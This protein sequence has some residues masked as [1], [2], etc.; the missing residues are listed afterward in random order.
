MSRKAGD[1]LSGENQQS[2][3]V[4]TSDG[5]EIDISP[6]KVIRL[7][8]WTI[9]LAFGIFGGWALTAPLQSAAHAPG[10]VG[11]RGDKKTVQ[12]YEGG[13]VE[14][15]LVA[16]GDS[17]QA[18]QVL[19]ELD[20]TQSRAQLE[21]TN[22]Q[23]LSAKAE[24]AR[25]MAEQQGLIRIAYVGEIFDS[26]D[27][28]AQ[29]AMIQQ[30]KVF[31]ARQKSRFGE[32]EVLEQKIEQ[33]KSRINGKKSLV[34]GK[35]QLV[36]SYLEEI[37]DYKALVEQGYSDKLRLRE[38]ERQ[39]ATLQSEIADSEASIAENMIEIGEARLE[40]IQ[41]ERRFQS[42]VA[43]EL[44]ETQDR[45]FEMMERRHA[46]KDRLDRTLIVAPVSGVVLDMSVTTVGGVV[47]P[48]EPILDVVPGG[49]DLVIKS[50][51]SPREIDR[52]AVG[53]EADI[54]FSAFNRRSTPVI[55]GTVTGVSADILIDD[56]SGGPYYSVSVEITED[57]LEQLGDLILIPGMP[58]EVLIKT[59]TQ[60]LFRYMMSPI[61][62]AFARSLIED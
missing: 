29:S 37:A 56:V 53:M 19:I 20:E 13:I 45:L 21:M 8:G 33:L 35:L 7:G 38:L 16:S 2:N 55:L 40:I 46:L 43:Q 50:K 54:R 49:S 4:I 32:I 5:R 14:A 41:I 23:F 1:S 12:H 10:V 6:D 31:N 11:I 24:E 59:G 28:R 51:L 17:V 26:E 9:L 22:G 39:V 3:L 44:G 42:S 62:D 48:G 36:E 60:T 25:L 61:E 30:N 57:E 27:P 34:K 58:A 47:K 52:V 15:L 18:G